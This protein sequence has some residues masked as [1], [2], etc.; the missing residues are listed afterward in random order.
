MAKVVGIDLGTTNSVVAVMEGG[1][2]SVIPNA[3]GF[4][5]TPSIVAYTKKGDKLVGQVAKRQAVLN[6]ENTFYS[7]KRFIG[8][9]ASEVSENLKK[10]S[11]N[12]KSTDVIKIQCPALNKE[13]ASEEISAQVL[14]KLAD[15]ATKYLGEPV[16]QAVVTVPAYFNDSQR[17]A[18]KDAGQIAGLEVLRIINEPTA[19][20]LSYGL[21]KKDNETILVFDLGGGTFD[22]SVLEVGEGVFEVLSTSGDTS[23]GGDDFDDKIVSWL[24][25]EFEND[26]NL[27]LTKDLQALQ[28]LTEAAEKAKVELSSVSQ[29]EINLPFIAISESGPKHL[30]RTLTVSKFE[31]LCSDLIERCSVPVETALKDANLTTSQID[32][33][34]LVGGSTRI[35]AIKKL[36]KE[37]LQKD[38]NE[39][40]NPDEVVAVGAAVQAGVLAGEVKDILL[41]DVTPLSLGVET[42]GG[43]STKIIPRNTTVPTKKSEVF[44]TADDNQS[45][46]EIVVL[47]GE[48]EFAKDNKRLGTF[49]LNGILPAPRGVPQI[50]VTFDTD[51]NGI[52]SVSAKDTG[53]GQ[54]QSI[55]I[56]GSSTLSRDEIDNM[57]QQAEENAAKDK[58][59]MSQVEA[60]NL[61]D[62]VLYQAEKQSLELEKQNLIS[63]ED[64]SELQSAIDNL[65]ESISNE[66]YEKMDSISK[67]I[68]QLLAS[69]G[70]KAYG[71]KAP[72]SESQQSSN[73]ASDDGVIDAEFSET[74]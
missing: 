18:T 41:L 68:Q 12:I 64:R 45:N 72:D 8:R 20:S 10:V 43:V 61:A 23:L 11:Y 22:V 69:I 7:V 44:S 70:S 46:V 6:P 53:T 42:V 63:D 5:S 33:V 21:E 3:E 2:P 30:E 74:K 14:R 28:R 29:T 58:E 32:E 54:E 38:P 17:Q 36:V 40:V 37:V 24:A 13:F 56:T 57:V 15:D 9:Q 31:Q 48:R 51:A 19:A 25:S 4:R 47:Q 67:E 35:P 26:E 39:T 71:N 49:R 55:T 52:L 62:S 27:D 16:T 50:E 73:S 1:K 66:N 34:V 65:K 59:R 60:K